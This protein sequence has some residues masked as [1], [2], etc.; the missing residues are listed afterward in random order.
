MDLGT[1]LI[2][3]APAAAGVAALVGGIKLLRPQRGESRTSTQRMLA[4]IFCL[5]VMMGCL[6]T[7]FAVGLCAGIAQSIH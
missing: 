7:S 4:G 1:I 5:F 2:V 3:L 6:L